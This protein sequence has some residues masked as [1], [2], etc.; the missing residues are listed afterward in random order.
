MGILFKDVSHAYK[1]VKDDR[2]E[3]INNINLEI[4]EGE[5]VAIIGKTGSG[6]S[7][8]VQH[9]NALLQPTKGTVHIFNHTLPKKKNQ[10]MYKTLGI[11]VGLVFVIILI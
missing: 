7:T 8:L 4:K 11:T 10:K 3:A 2:F 5:F 9:M 6:K 1:G